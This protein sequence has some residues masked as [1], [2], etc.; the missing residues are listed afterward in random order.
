MNILDRPKFP[1]IQQT[2]I[3]TIGPYRPHVE[4]SPSLVTCCLPLS[5]DWLPPV[6]CPAGSVVIGQGPLTLLGDAT[7][8]SSSTNV[9][10]WCAGR[11]Y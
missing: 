8:R 6:T 11:V 2:P 5:S 3:Y 1:R 9:C 7:E 10:S 4:R